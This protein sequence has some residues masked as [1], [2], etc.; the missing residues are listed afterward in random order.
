MAWAVCNGIYLASAFLNA[1]HIE[2]LSGQ[3]AL[4]GSH[5]EMQWSPGLVL[6]FVDEPV[7]VLLFWAFLLV[8]VHGS[9]DKLA[10]DYNNLYTVCVTIV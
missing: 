4:P 1:L 5:K 6:P 8:L 2:S 7:F 3:L 10:L 9:K